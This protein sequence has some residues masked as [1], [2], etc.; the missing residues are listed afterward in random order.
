[1][2]LGAGMLLSM[3]AAILLVVVWYPSSGRRTIFW[4]LEA[5]WAIE[6][7]GPSLP[8]LAASALLSVAGAVPFSSQI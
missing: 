4:I 7:G 3:A 1:M 5:D 2:A 8:N 6:D